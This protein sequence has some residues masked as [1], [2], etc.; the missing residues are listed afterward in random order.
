M[1]EKK[2]LI[3]SDYYASR[4]M[5]HIKRKK[6][7]IFIMI[8]GEWNV[9]RLFRIIFAIDFTRKNFNKF[10]D[11]SFSRRKRPLKTVN[12]ISASN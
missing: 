10:T 9:E 6:M 3:G 5:Q 4:F 1:R 12:L 8:C 11:Q 7:M 2:E